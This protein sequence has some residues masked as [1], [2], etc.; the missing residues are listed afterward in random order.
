MRLQPFGNKG[1]IAAFAKEPVD[2]LV[3]NQCVIT[4]AAMDFVAIGDGMRLAGKRW[5]DLHSEWSSSCGRAVWIEDTNEVGAR[6]KGAQ[7]DKIFAGCQAQT[8]AIEEIGA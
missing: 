6:V 2:I 3:A 4:V 5:I 7:I 1:V 8:T